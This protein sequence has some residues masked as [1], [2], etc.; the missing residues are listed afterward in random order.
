M[1][2]LGLRLQPDRGISLLGDSDKRNWSADS[3]NDPLG[4]SSTFVKDKSKSH[5]PPAQ[6]IGNPSVPFV[7]A[8]LLIVSKSEECLSSLSCST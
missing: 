5:A 8:Y 3:V 1:S 2:S 7:A 4:Q 6:D